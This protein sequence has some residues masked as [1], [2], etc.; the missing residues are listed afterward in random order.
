M[1][2]FWRRVFWPHPTLPVWKADTTV[3][4]LVLGGL[5]LNWL[6]IRKIGSRC[7]VWGR[8]SLGTTD[9]PRTD[10][11]GPRAAAPLKEDD[12]NLA[13]DHHRS[14]VDTES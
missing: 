5:R 2:R 10:P 14:G 8:L 13:A 7:C 3:D 1:I 4:P 11:A 9:T 6:P 12:R